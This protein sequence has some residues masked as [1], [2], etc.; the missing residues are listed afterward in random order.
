MEIVKAWAWP[1][2]S[3]PIVKA[4]LRAGLA[5]SA[6]RLRQSALEVR[7]LALSDGLEKRER[8]SIWN[9]KT[10]L[11]SAQSS[12]DTG[13]NIFFLNNFRGGRQFQKRPSLLLV[14]RFK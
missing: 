13:K 10:G 3:T 2:V 1:A 11:L 4:T 5:N 6:Q 7:R 8:V 12:G 9:W 14:V